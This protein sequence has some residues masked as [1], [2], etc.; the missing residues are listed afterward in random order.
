MFFHG[1]GGAGGGAPR[2]SGRQSQIVI[3]G[4]QGRGPG[5]FTYPR[6]L[7]V[8]PDED[9]LVID[10]SGRVVRMSGDGEYRS[11]WD[12]PAWQNGTPTDLTLARDGTVWIADTHYHRL[13]HYT[14]EGVLLEQ[15]G[16][17]GDGDGQFVY[18]TS[19]DFDGEGNFY[20]TEYG[21][22]SRV[23]KFTAAFEFAAAWGDPGT[24]SAEG[25]G[26]L[27][28]PMKVRVMPDGTLLVADSCN[29]RLVRFSLEGAF[30]GAIGA[31]GVGPGQT[32]FLYD[33]DF[34]G[35]GRLYAC[36]YGN[37]RIV[38]FAADGVPLGAFGH[39]GTDPGGLHNPWGVAVLADGR[40][41]VADTWNHRLQSFP[42]TILDA[43]PAQ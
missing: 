22:H 43:E 12:L 35:H 20:V 25:W 14:Q 6:A 32:R 4:R 27:S 40:I 42:G 9:V 7:C 33:F 13:L 8:L 15:R 34:D 26:G 2:A 24:P 29:H 11:H 30:L 28:R 17:Y 10:R 16:E 36:D 19:V 21:E 41:L 23:Q 37:N 39:P 1:C 3:I 38:V 18:P 31:E 5:E